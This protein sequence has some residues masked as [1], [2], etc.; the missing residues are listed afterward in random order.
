MTVRRT[1][2]LILLMASLA[3]AGCTDD[4]ANALYAAAKIFQKQS[5]AALE[6][7]ETLI[8][9][10]SLGPAISSDERTA[11]FL[12]TQIV[13]YKKIAPADQPNWRPNVDYLRTALSDEHFRQKLESSVSSEFRTTR[14]IYAEMIEAFALLPDAQFLGVKPVKCSEQ[15]VAQLANQMAN[16]AQLL[17][18]S[19]IKFISRAER[20]NSQL[21]KAIKDSHAG[22]ADRKM[23]LNALAG[24][25]NEEARLNRDAVEKS[26]AA[27]DAG[28]KLLAL[29]QD[30]D[31]ITVK[32]I[33]AYADKL[34]PVAN[35]VEGAGAD[36]QLR[37]RIDVIRTKFE[38]DERL[39]RLARIDLNAEERIQ[40]R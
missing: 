21:A 27:A 31:R 2:M 20:L 28:L 1:I 26:L 10:S 35:L 34:A 38:T 40:C 7:Y 11:R 19:P 16:N 3:V 8:V 24:V 37:G 6:A 18:D 15:L 36:L 5:E 25:I 4:K 14:R 29:V 12:E 33:L 22:E 39:K 23:A 9:Q 17:A 13:E 30:Y 32:E